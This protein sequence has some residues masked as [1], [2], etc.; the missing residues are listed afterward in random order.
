[1]LILKPMPLEFER[2]P[3]CA[4]TSAV[5]IWEAVVGPFHEDDPIPADNWF[6]ILWKTGAPMAGYDALKALFALIPPKA[7]IVKR[8]GAPNTGMATAVFSGNGK[9]VIAIVNDQDDPKEITVTVK[10]AQVNNNPD[11]RIWTANGD[12]NTVKSSIGS[13]KTVGSG[14]T[15]TVT[16]MTIDSILVLS[17]T[18]K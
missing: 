18:K 7:D 8:Q 16:K 12:D 9:I 2:Q 17:Y 15:V 14:F 11:L 6:G 5:Y 4:G 1:M 10:N 13:P 3:L